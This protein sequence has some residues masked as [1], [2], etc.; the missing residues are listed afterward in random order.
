MNLKFKK[1]RSWENFELRIV[2]DCTLKGLIMYKM[3]EKFR[4]VY[5]GRATQEKTPF[6]FFGS[7]KGQSI[8]F[9]AKQ[10]AKDKF[11][12]SEHVH[13]PKKRHQFT[14]LVDAHEKGC[15]AG[16][17]VYFAKHETIAWISI[18]TILYHIDCG[19]VGIQCGDLPSCNYQDYKEW[20]DLEKLIEEVL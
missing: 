7:I 19:K 12:F 20:L 8:Y 10:T 9:D 4:G 14:A 5:S 13:N 3:P 15:I 18:D 2:R 16:Y 1:S 11:M 17:L 6:D